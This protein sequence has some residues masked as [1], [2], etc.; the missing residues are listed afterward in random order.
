[1][2]N[3]PRNLDIGK[4]L[5]TPK[6]KKVTK[7]FYFIGGGV[8][9]RTFYEYSHEWIAIYPHEYE[10]FFYNLSKSRK[11]KIYPVGCYQDC[12]Y[13]I[14]PNYNRELLDY[15]EIVKYKY[16]KVK[17]ISYNDLLYLIE[18]IT[19]MQKYLKE[20]NI[21][22]IQTDPSKLVT[23]IVYKS[24]QVVACRILEEHK[25]FLLDVSTGMPISYRFINNEIPYVIKSE[26]KK[27]K[28]DSN[29]SLVKRIFKK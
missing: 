16:D 22:S 15:L 10:S 28:P 8:T 18:P 4:V 23:G 26:I 2:I 12:E 11:D 9:S 21:D 29:K 24:D 5:I 19:H 3:V 7:N 20:K 27:F 13:V 25:Y 1:M 17:N 14:N 6:Y